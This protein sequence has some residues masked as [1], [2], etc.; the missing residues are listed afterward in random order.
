MPAPISLFGNEGGVTKTSTAIPPRRRI[1][2]GP[3][4]ALEFELIRISNTLNSCKTF[5]FVQIMDNISLKIFIS[6]EKQ[7]VFLALFSSRYLAAQF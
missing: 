6:T 4:K 2:K 1:P 7:R 3:E 5:D